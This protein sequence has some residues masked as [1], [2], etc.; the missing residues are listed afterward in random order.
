MKQVGA[1]CELSLSLPQPSDG[2][3]VDLIGLDQA[4]SYRCRPIGVDIYWYVA[5]KKSSSE[6]GGIDI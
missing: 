3:G 1:N 2:A 5:H 6:V 4:K